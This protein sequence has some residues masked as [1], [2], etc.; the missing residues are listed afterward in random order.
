VRVAGA[1]RMLPSISFDDEPALLA[2]E[3]RDERS[4]R[5]LPPEFGA[6][7]LPVAQH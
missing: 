3:V 5:L 2:D 4:D 6:I 7:E 1:L